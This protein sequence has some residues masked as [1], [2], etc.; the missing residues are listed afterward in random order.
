MHAQNRRTTSGA[1]IV[2]TVSANANVTRLGVTV[3]A[4]GGFAI[5]IPARLFE[6]AAPVGS[7][8]AVQVTTQSGAELP[9]WL[10]FDRSSMRLNAANVPASGLPLTIKLA[11]GAGKSVEVTFK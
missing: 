2:S 1:V 10:T 5:A 11:A 3:E 4:G 9:S 8:A 6:S 7:G